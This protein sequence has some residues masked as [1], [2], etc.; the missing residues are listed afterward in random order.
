VGEGATASGGDVNVLATAVAGRGLVPP[1][2]P[3][4]AADDEALLRGRA[5]FE[6]AR[7]Y[8]GRPF[9]LADHLERLRLSAA[10][11]RL[12]E[13]DAAECARLAALVVEAAGEPE[14]A[15]R[16]Y[17]TGTTLVATAGAVAP[18]LE[19]LRARG[20]RLATV[21]WSAGM[22]AGAKSTSYAEN[23]AAQ[24]VAATQGADDALLVAPD[25]TVLEAPTA[26]VWWREGERILT[27][28]LALPVL[29]GVTRAVL[30]EI[31]P[32]A[33]YVATEGVLPAARIVEVDELFLSSSIREVM[34]VVSVDGAAVGGGVPGLAATA[35]QQALR[36]AAGVPSSE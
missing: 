14:L 32:A 16:L 10:R 5:V 15:V 1:H 34:P 3:V 11:V 12:P 33:G 7:V 2:E 18:D 36:S 22:L 17:W 13:P 19:E 9:R 23:M 29:A 28:P 27:P 6:T 8:G 25:G 4:F 30:F 35:L 31:A 20:L 21:P 26:N 24:D